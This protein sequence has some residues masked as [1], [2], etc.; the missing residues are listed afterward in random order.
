MLPKPWCR[1]GD[2]WEVDFTMA[3]Y[4]V[5]LGSIEFWVVLFCFV[6]FCLFIHFV[7]SFYFPT[8]FISFFIYISNAIPK[9]PYT[10]PLCSLTHSLPLLGPSIPLY[11]GI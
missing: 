11:W 10:S 8:F 9:V 1:L 4:S 2:S 6:L 5:D 7:V 3:V